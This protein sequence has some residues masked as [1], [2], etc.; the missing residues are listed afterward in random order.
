MIPSITEK[1]GTYGVIKGS[2]N[3][4]GATVAKKK[5][6]MEALGYEFE[7]LILY[8]TSL[9]IGTCWLGGTFNRGSFANALEV[10]ANEIFPIVSPFGYAASK[11]RLAD[12]LVRKIAKSDQR[13]PWNKL[14][15]SKNF[16]TILEK[17]DIGA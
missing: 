1:L 3:Y 6:A 15:F 9:N 8:L 11:R 17:K 12:A 2:Q 10:N 7:K 16:D 13:E 4:I 5:L 14:F